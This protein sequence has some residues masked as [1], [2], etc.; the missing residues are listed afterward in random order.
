MQSNFRS[1]P[2]MNSAAISPIREHTELG[3]GKEAM[4]VTRAAHSS[5]RFEA[6][7]YHMAFAEECAIF[8]GT[9]LMA[10]ILPLMLR[11][12]FGYMSKRAM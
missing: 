3:A 2:P 5:G 1:D 11:P 8:K 10:S 9:P 4:S 7:L 12:M 6:K